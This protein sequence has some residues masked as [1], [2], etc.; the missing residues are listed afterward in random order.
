MTIDQRNEIALLSVHYKKPER[1]LTVQEHEKIPLKDSP[2]DTGYMEHSSIKGVS[3]CYDGQRPLDSLVNGFFVGK[4][5]SIY[6][7]RLVIMPKPDLNEG[8]LYGMVDGLQPTPFQNVQPNS[9]LSC[10]VHS[11]S[12]TYECVLCVC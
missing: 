12:T 6:E 3:I 8:D 11:T 7:T 2:K 4:V 1:R 9:G 10:N 5:P